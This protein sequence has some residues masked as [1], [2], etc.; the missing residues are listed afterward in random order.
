MRSGNKKI[1]KKAEGNVKKD[2]GVQLVE[3]SQLKLTCKKIKI[4][5]NL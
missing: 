3:K 4:K 2:I 5:N 1:N